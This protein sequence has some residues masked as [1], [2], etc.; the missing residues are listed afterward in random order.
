MTRQFLTGI[1]ALALATAASAQNNT[2]TYN[3]TGAGNS[4]TV[5]NTI[6]GNT[7]N[8][9][10]IIQNGAS[11]SATVFQRNNA[12]GSFIEQL[13]I[14][15]T[16]THQQVGSFNQASSRQNGDFQVTASTQVGSFNS[17]SIMQVGSNNRSYVRQG[18]AL[19][20]NIPEGELRAADANSA[21]IDQSGY[22][23]YSLVNQRA[24]SASL[25]PA[26]DN[27]AFVTQRSS[28]NT[29]SVQQSSTMLQESRGNFAR[30]S[31]FDG[32]ASAPNS[33]TIEQRNEL[34]P[35]VMSL[36]SAT[37]EQRGLGQS[38]RI[39][40]NGVSNRASAQM[41]GGDLAGRG[42]VSDVSQQG[43]GNISSYANIRV[44]AGRGIS[45]NGTVSQS[46]N[47]HEISVY[48]SGV[49]DRSFVTQVNGVD[50]FTYSDG[51]RARA[52]ALISQNADA[53]SASL[54][55]V[56]D[57]YGEIVQG[58]GAGMQAS[59]NQT[60][61]GDSSGERGANSA[62]ISQ[63]GASNVLT[64][65]QNS[66]GA[67]A[68]AWQQ[69][70]SSSNTGSIR[71]G[72]GGTALP[73]TT[74]VP[75]FTAGPVGSATSG[76]NAELIQAG[77]GNRAQILQD[78][79]SLRAKVEQRGVATSQNANSVLVSQTGIG[80]W[81]AAFQGQLVGESSAGDPASGNS[82]AQNSAAGGTAVAD[83]F[84]FAGGSRSAELSILQ[85]NSNNSAS[86]AQYGRGQLARIEQSGSG[87]LGSIVQDSNATNATA[88][89]RQTGTNNSY[90]ITQTS[91]GQYVVVVQ[92]GASN[93]ASNVVQR[94]P[95]GGSVGITPP[96][97][98]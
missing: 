31:Q 55:Q 73:A 5:D 27:Q 97:G 58:F 52:R 95:S 93:S 40:Q 61:A 16:S 96:P 18:Y 2:S 47:S 37:V 50:N 72:D 77:S 53:A 84:Y 3:Q 67:T 26:S 69:V 49:G 80:N 6:T 11:N 83:E 22:G 92:S 66:I 39:V 86:I 13:G 98:G 59:V 65:G 64:I 29:T 4:A 20:A 42:N 1:S 78:G 88:V 94:G 38:S 85:T 21:N 8:S 79:V 32:A 48:Q 56:G 30:T 12:N 87:N 33:S 17:S 24:A 62:I 74:S 63:Y 44:M 75:G 70:G 45:N 23:L 34:S 10:T 35:Q 68:T 54:I 36:N 91:S 7:N 14:F 43:T 46:G 25:P 41:A 57:N 9:A 81:A 71:Q 15:N 76:L 28:A 82:A 19:E 60:D 90:Y 51:A 89:L